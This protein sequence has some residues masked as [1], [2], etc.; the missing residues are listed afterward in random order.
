MFYFIAAFVLLQMRFVCDKIKKIDGATIVQ[1]LA[2]LLQYALILFY[3]IAHETKS[4][5]T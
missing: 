4:A 1:A 2:R 3:F 5:I